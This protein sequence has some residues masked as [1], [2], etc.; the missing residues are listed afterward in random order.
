MSEVK[1]VLTERLTAA[2]SNI[3]AAAVWEEWVSEWSKFSIN[4]LMRSTVEIIKE[5]LSDAYVAKI[6]LDETK[7]AKLL[8]WPEAAITAFSVF[9]YTEQ[10]DHSLVLYLRDELGSW[11]SDNMHRIDG[12]TEE[13]IK[14]FLQPINGI[15]LSEKIVYNVTVQKI[16]Y[17]HDVLDPDN[18]SVAIDAYHTI[19]GRR[20]Q[21]SGNAVIVTVP[22]HAIRQIEFVNTI[23][24]QSFPYDFYKAVEDI[25]YGPSTKIMIQSRTKFWENETVGE[26]KITGGFSKTNLP[27]GQLH[28]PTSDVPAPNDKGILLCYTW[29]AEALLFGSLPEKVAVERVVRQIAQIHPEIIDEF[30]TGAVHAWYSDPGAQGA[31]VLLKPHQYRHVKY[32]MNYPHKNLFFAG[33]GISHGPGWIQGALESTFRAA[34]QFYLRNEEASAAAAKRKK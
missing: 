12:G 21:F 2:G 9:N 27:I 8:P 1:R 3:E 28:Y 18:T 14:K 23:A 5:T 19:S 25:W 34:Y 6:G 17:S 15:N 31:Y 10:L 33:E 22:L 26:P 20:F 24:S 16:T 7:L 4:S 32:L 13:L 11:W 29:K 30:E